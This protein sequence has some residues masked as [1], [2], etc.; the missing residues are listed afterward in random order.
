[1]R[2]IL[3]KPSIV[4][5]GLLGILFFVSNASAQDS[6]C[7]NY[8]RADFTVSG[9]IQRVKISKSETIWVLLLL[10]KKACFDGGAAGGVDV[11]EHGVTDLQLLLSPEEYKQYQS[12]VNKN[13]VITGGFF[14]SHTAHHYTKVLMDVEKIE[15]KK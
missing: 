3:S 5:F 4:I 7:Y 12:F 1:M 2:K 8:E 9:K 11:P 10:P 13:V 15:L 6:K 14:H